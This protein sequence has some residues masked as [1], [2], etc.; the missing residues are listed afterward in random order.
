MVAHH[1]LAKIVLAQDELDRDACARAKRLSQKPPSLRRAEPRRIAGHV[2]DH[3]LRRAERAAAE[4]G[5]RLSRW[6][7]LSLNQSLSVGDREAGGIAQAAQQHPRV[8]KRGAAADDAAERCCAPSGRRTNRRRDWRA[9]PRWRRSCRPAPTATAVR[10]RS[11]SPSASSSSVVAAVARRARQARAR[12]RPAGGRRGWTRERRRRRRRTRR[13]RRGP[14]AGAA[15]PPDLFAAETTDRAV[16]GLG[17]GI[18]AGQRLADRRR[19]VEA[20]VRAEARRPST[21]WRADRDPGTGS[22]RG[23]AAGT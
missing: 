23:H 20:I 7:K 14:V 18:G 22:A 12:C 1:L 17:N 15:Q 5:A 11:G 4:I 16:R 9:L 19:C 13:T 10:Q 8:P 3:D 6:A 21:E 2:A